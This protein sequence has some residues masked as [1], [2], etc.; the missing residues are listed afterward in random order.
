M[1]NLQIF[2]ITLNPLHRNLIEKLNY[3]P[4]G[5][6]NK[7]FGK[8]W[9]Q[10]RRGDNIAFKNPHYGE[11]TFHYWLWKNNNINFNGWIGFC[12]YRKFWKN[13][14]D[15]KQMTDFDS[16]DE[17]VLKEIP[18]E[19]EKFDSILLESQFVNQ[20]RLSKF[21]KHNLKTM[22]LDPKLL[23]NENKRT[24]KFHFDMMHGHGNLDKAIDVMDKKEKID[25]KN[26]VNKEVSFNPQNM[27]I[28]KNKEILFSYYESLFP[29][30]DNCEKIF[31]FQKLEGFGLKRIYGFLAE[32]YLSYWFKKYTKHT[33]LPMQ[34]KD[35]S[36]YL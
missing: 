29:W 1:K 2:C 4:V 24:I 3:T 23:F 8:G 5:L 31:G 18:K 12:Q 9:L 25:F 10:D 16:L 7:N 34:F 35:I 20:F 13:R 28:C 11:Y 6:G 26:F 36:D 32:R 17:I 22:I 27:F 15:N 30:L 21:V 19:L 33:V 14:A